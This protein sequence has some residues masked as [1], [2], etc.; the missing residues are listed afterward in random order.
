[1][2][3]L[4][5]KNQAEKQY[6]Y[7]KDNETVYRIRWPIMTS[8][9]EYVDP[10][11]LFI[12]RSF[13]AD[14]DYDE[15]EFN[16][17]DELRQ[18]AYDDS[19][20]DKRGIVLDPDNKHE[21]IMIFAPKEI[22]EDYLSRIEKLLSDNSYKGIDILFLQ[23]SKNRV[24]LRDKSLSERLEE[25]KNKYNESRLPDIGLYIELIKCDIKERLSK[26]KNVYSI[27]IAA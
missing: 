4:L 2:I 18:Y 21:N 17:I 20:P 6:Y 7:T 23:L 25:L 15:R 19:S 22:V 11:D 26:R 5:A 14:F 24:L 1:M 27:N 3:K 9:E 10:I 13:D 16:N 12:H 8:N